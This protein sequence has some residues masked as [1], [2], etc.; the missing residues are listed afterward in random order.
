MISCLALFYLRNPNAAVADM[1]GSNIFNV[2]T[3]FMNDLITA[4]IKPPYSLFKQDKPAMWLAI[5]SIIGCAI[6]LVALLILK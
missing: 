3:L 1:L 6:F 5:F 2:F 4:C